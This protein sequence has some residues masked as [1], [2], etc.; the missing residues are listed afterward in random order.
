MQSRVQWKH[1]QR[2]CEVNKAPSVGDV[3]HR[4]W[5]RVIGE[6]IVNGEVG[7]DTRCHRFYPKHLLRPDSSTIWKIG[8]CVVPESYSRPFGDVDN[9]TFYGEDGISKDDRL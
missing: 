6:N 2:A 5:G 3:E 4:H 7:V 1:R 9:K 8:K